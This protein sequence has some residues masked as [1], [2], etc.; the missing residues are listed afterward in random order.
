MAC[1][2]FTVFETHEGWFVGGLHPIG[3]FFSKER[4]VDLAEGMVAA[5]LATGEDAN[6]VVEEAKSWAP[7]ETLLRA[8]VV[9]RRPEAR[10][11]KRPARLEAAARRQSGIRLDSGRTGDA[12]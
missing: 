3:P 9:R 8:K 7:T 2:S 11:P 5:I 12:Q 6:L 1:L 4:A 10:P